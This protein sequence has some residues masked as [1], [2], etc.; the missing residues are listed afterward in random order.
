MNLIANSSKLS[1]LN[2][3]V[4]IL[5][6]IALLC[7]P[8]ISF[9]F[10]IFESTRDVVGYIQEFSSHIPT[11]YIG[12]LSILMWSTFFFLKDEKYS[13]LKTLTRSIATLCMALL[14]MSSVY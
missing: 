7:I 11:T 14:Y 8:P 2:N 3:T 4:L 5:C 12:I 1:Y 13:E 6:G 9:F 10:L